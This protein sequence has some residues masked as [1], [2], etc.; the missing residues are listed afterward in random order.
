MEK[1]ESMIFYGSWL[2]AVK[3]LPREMQGEVLTAIIEYG[4]TGET[5]ASLKPVTKAMLAMAKGQ[6][7][8]NRK[9]YENGVVN[10]KK[11]GRPRKDDDD[12]L[13]LDFDNKE[14]QSQQ[15]QEQPQ[16]QK[17]ETVEMNDEQDKEVHTWE[18]TYLKIIN[19]FNHAIHVNNSS[20]KPVRAISDSRRKALHLLCSKGFKEADYKKAFRNVAVSDYCN[21]R[22]KDRQ[23]PADFDWII[24]EEN[25]NRAYEGSL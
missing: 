18:N 17:E 2:E 5:T 22:T 23:K 3:N 11:G 8:A 6:I 15:N 4:L 10:G 7:D 14:T 9:K 12:E 20:I 24:R 19:L 16:T 21:G 25:F 13:S 1:R